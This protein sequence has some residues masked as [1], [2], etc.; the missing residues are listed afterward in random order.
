M[1]RQPICAL[2]F[3]TYEA[4]LGAGDASSWPKATSAPPL[5]HSPRPSIGKAIYCPLIGDM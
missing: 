5:L 3:E 1:K 4:C 2:P